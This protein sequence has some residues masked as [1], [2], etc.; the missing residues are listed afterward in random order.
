MKKLQ[1]LIESEGFD[2]LEDFLD[3]YSFDSL[4]PGIC[5]NPGCDYT[6]DVEP[7][8]EQGWCELCETHTVCAGTRLAGVI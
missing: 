8:Q 3:A 4:V 7:D 6:T 2:D 5:L 1:D